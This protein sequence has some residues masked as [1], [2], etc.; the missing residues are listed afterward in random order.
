MFNGL[1]MGAGAYPVQV[2]A[3]ECIMVNS[4]RWRN[5]FMTWISVSSS[6]G[7]LGMLLIANF[8]DYRWISVIAAILCACILAVFQLVIPESPAWL[9]RQ[10]RVGDAEWSQK[11]LG[12]VQPILQGEGSICEKGESQRAHRGSIFVRQMRVL[13]RPDVYKPIL[14]LSIAST[15][16]SFCGTVTVV[17]YMI[18]IIDNTIPGVESSTRET[19]TVNATNATSEFVL[20]KSYEY[21]LVSGV[22]MCLGSLL[23]IMVLPRMGLKKM[24]IASKVFIIL[25][26][27]ALT[28]GTVVK[29]HFDESLRIAAVT[30]LSFLMGLE[31][32]PRMSF[33][34]DVFPVD[35]KG[36]A[37]IPALTGSVSTATANKIFPYL[38]VVFGGYAYLFYA[39]ASVFGIIY[40]HYFL[41]EVVGRTLDEI[42]G[43]FKKDKK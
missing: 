2:Y 28:Y 25:G 33:S 16:L 10:G 43:D 18:N 42:H 5:I 38:R 1:T 19:L 31:L 27:V 41:P 12:I 26:L 35:A 23:S 24:F 8:I 22:C 21:S 40:I 29:S 17:T 20:P 6:V 13:T 11:K 30:L 7:S 9:Y 3:G 34:G 15:V 4:V 14:I 39:L 37:S 32:G 36:F